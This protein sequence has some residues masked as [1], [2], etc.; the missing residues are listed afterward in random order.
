MIH[1]ERAIGG[2]LDAESQEQ[3]REGAER[4]AVAGRWK[5]DGQ[6]SRSKTADSAS[7]SAHNRA[8]P[9]AR[10]D[11]CAA[12][13]PG[14]RRRRRLSTGVADTDPDDVLRLSPPLDANGYQGQYSLCPFSA[15]YDIRLLD[16]QTYRGVD[17][18]I[19]GGHS[20]KPDGTIPGLHFF[21]TSNVEPVGVEAESASGESRLAHIP[22]ETE[23]L[24]NAGNSLL[25]LQELLTC[26]TVLADSG[27]RLASFVALHHLLK[28]SPTPEQNRLARR[29]RTKR[30]QNHG[31]RP[32]QPRNRNSHGICAAKGDAA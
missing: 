22:T 30:K 12:P 20:P 5:W 21:L 2:A 31:Q 17:R 3:A 18:S 24:R 11:G 26:L 28:T 15:P 1:I 32:S 10:S 29:N 4:S 16:G 7:T 27:G 8:Q 25:V 23:H 6:S 19:R 9:S 13:R 14:T